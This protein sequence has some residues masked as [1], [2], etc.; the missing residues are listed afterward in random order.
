LVFDRYCGGQDFGYVNL[1]K[2]GETRGEREAGEMVCVRKDVRVLILFSIS[3]RPLN[4]S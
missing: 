1:E 4:I 2:L 3:S